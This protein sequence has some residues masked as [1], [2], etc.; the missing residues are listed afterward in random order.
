MEEHGVENAQ[1]SPYCGLRIYWLIFFFFWESITQR[2]FLIRQ[3]SNRH[4]CS[5]RVSSN[6]SRILLSVLSILFGNS[7]PEKTTCIRR[8]IKIK[9]IWKGASNIT[10]DR[11]EYLLPPHSWFVDFRQFLKWKRSLLSLPKITRKTPKFSENRFYEKNVIKILNFPRSLF[12]H[13]TLP[14]K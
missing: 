3:V 8:R 9:L 2:P 13:L 10:E 6:N 5:S 7:F 12:D 14:G 1:K 11:R 4:D